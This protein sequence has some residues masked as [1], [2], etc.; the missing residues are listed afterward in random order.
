MQKDADVNLATVAPFK[1]HSNSLV[2]N[3]ECNHDDYTASVRLQEALGHTG[4]KMTKAE[5]RSASSNHEPPGL[6][7]KKVC[8]FGAF[9]R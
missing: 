2:E 5:L 8:D 9:A 7:D 4:A 1:I 6:I 3:I